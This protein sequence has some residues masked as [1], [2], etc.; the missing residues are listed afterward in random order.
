M[1]I[2]VCI[3]LVWLIW[4]ASVSGRGVA[5]EPGWKEMKVFENSLPEGYLAPGPGAICYQVDIFLLLI[6]NQ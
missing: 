6:I 5:G 1:H 2:A 3:P 4:E